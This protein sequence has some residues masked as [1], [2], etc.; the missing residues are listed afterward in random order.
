MD[1]LAAFSLA[2]RRALV[3]GSSRGIGFAIAQALAGA[4]AAVVLNSRDTAAL[5]EAAARLA[6]DGADVRAAAFDVTSA[7]SVGDAI[8]WME[9]ELGPIDILVNNVGMQHRAPLVPS[10]GSGRAMARTPNRSLP[11]G[12]DRMT[13]MP[14]ES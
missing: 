6:D 10:A 5:G 12:T 2:G 7:E 13:V 4:G 14:D 11:Y 8:D 9:G 3:T 1:S